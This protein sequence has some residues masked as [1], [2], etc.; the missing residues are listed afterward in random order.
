[1]PDHPPQA[2]QAASR[3]RAFIRGALADP[4]WLLREIDISLDRVAF[5]PVPESGYRRSPFLDH[6]LEGATGQP[7]ITRCDGLL[8][9][10]G[11]V[12]PGPTHWIFHPGHVGSTLLSRLL[13]EIEDVLPLREPLPLRYL[14]G[15]TR[16]LGTPLSRLDEAGF[17]RFARAI[18]ACLGRR[19][20]PGQIPLVKA[21]SDCC[22]LLERSLAAH[23]ESRAVWIHVDLET[24]LAGML[25][26]EAR[27]Q[28]TRAFAQSRLQDLHGLLGDGEIRLYELDIGQTT[29]LSW[30]ANQGHRLRASASGVHDR[31][32]TLHFHDLL[33][34]PETVLPDI[35]AHLGLPADSR[36][37]ARV[38]DSPWLGTYA[39]A[40]GTA[41][42]ANQRFS[43]L[44]ASRR[45][46]AAAI[47]AGLAFAREL[48]ARHAD[49]A[50][51]QS[52][53]RA[54]AD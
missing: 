20:R 45:D 18:W 31:L 25:R 23:P 52:D 7:V 27:R 1:M 38:L 40:P 39:K 14:A 43:Q 24:F 36:T 44:D 22:N 33:A 30:L 11:S 6:R 28:E 4:S 54:R 16:E 2:E 21:T 41:F 3:E 50:P 49:L 9:E 12:T 53:L 46:N 48:C 51:L 26:N 13:G 19:F 42:D 15:L 17:E 35:L 37:V 10:A 34:S 32:F 5:V 47:R 8:S 29:A